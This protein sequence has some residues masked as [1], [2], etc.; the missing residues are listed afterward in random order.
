M[1]LM[2]A[3]LVGVSVNAVVQ[4]FDRNEFLARVRAA[5]QP[6]EALLSDGDEFDYERAA[7]FSG[8]LNGTDEH[9]VVVLLD[10]DSASVQKAKELG[11]TLEWED[12][13]I[14]PLLAIMVLPPT[15]CIR[16]VEYNVP[17]LIRG[18]SSGTTPKPLILED[19]SSETLRRGGLV[20][21][22]MGCTSSSR[23]HQG[24]S[25]DLHD[26]L[27]E[28]ELGSVMCASRPLI[29]QYVLDLVSSGAVA[30]EAVKRAFSRVKRHRF[31]DHWY[32][33]EADR[34]QAT[35]S[36]IPFDRDHPDAESLREMTRTP[37]LSL[38]S[39]ASTRPARRPL[40]N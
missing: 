26:R 9:L 12:V 8:Y 34:L 32:R 21:Q 6:L 29:E 1:G 15:D 19:V 35:W 20:A 18:L 3:V 23:E 24:A 25:S 40:L 31:L 11:Y 10:E 7:L 2:M 17:Y 22:T 38:G 28:P 39:T 14:L 27:D 4:M 5:F 37:R 16:N 13:G 36:L 33:L 30:S